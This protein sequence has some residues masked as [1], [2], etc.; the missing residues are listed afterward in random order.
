MTDS[1][2]PL[3][4]S[5]WKWP[6]GT[7]KTND[8]N[9]NDAQLAPAWPNLFDESFEML[10]AATLM[11]AFADLRQLARKGMLEGGAGELIMAVP[12]TVD[13]VMSVVQQNTATLRRVFGGDSMVEFYTN[14]LGNLR[15]RQEQQRSS[16]WLTSSI[17]QNSHVSQVVVF[18]DE[19][20]QRELVYGISVNQARQRITVAFRGSVTTSDFT[21]DAN[22]IINN[23]PNPVVTNQH[24][25]E[26]RQSNFVGIH[27]GFYGKCRLSSCYDDRVAELAAFLVIAYRE[28]NCC[29]VYHFRLSFWR[30]SQ[31]H[32][33]V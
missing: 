17:I 18:D 3:L 16:T 29:C 31:R 26:I 13:D 4:P 9:N 6:F 12:I 23:I 8:T 21:T 28:T 2:E 25:T 10:M 1:K 5:I 22:A 19:N 30:S 32:Q 24:S 27:H 15:N 11:Y 33:Q 7:T 20:H 14:S